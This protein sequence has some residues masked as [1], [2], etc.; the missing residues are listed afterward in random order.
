MLPEIRQCHSESVL[1][2]VLALKFVQHKGTE[3]RKKGKI[4]EKKVLLRQ[5]RVARLREAKDEFHLKCT[6]LK[7]ELTGL[8]DGY[9]LVTEES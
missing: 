1:I 7:E 8:A 9:K 6:G 3:W 2:G 5:Q 4:D